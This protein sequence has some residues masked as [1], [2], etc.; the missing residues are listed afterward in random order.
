MLSSDVKI[1][2]PEEGGV[3]SIPTPL[4]CVMCNL[5]KETTAG[6]DELVAAAVSTSSTSTSSTATSGASTAS[7]VAAAT[8]VRDRVLCINLSRDAPTLPPVQPDDDVEYVPPAAAVAS[9]AAAPSLFTDNAMSTARQS[10]KRKAASGP[11][12]KKD[13]S[14]YVHFRITDLPDGGKLSDYLMCAPCFILLFLPLTSQSILGVSSV[15]LHCSG[16]N[17]P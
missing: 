6:T 8:S 11:K 10:N 17:K 15:C 7:S 4:S 16:Y 13:E 12:K 14:L 2:H 9:V 3:Y 5:C 1:L